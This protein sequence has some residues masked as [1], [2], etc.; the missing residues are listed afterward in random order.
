MG[1]VYEE[2]SV[3]GAAATEVLKT[4]GVAITALFVPGF[5]DTV[6]TL[7]EA[8]S[9]PYSTGKGTGL[10]STVPCSSKVTVGVVN[11]HHFTLTSR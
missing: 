3:L 11:S 5:S 7:R 1:Q 4:A 10:Q 6:Q 9:K 2:V 8:P